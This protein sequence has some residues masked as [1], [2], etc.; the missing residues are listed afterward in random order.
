MNELINFFSNDM[1]AI[2]WPEAVIVRGIILIITGY[3]FIAWRRRKAQM[4]YQAWALFAT[5]VNL[6]LIYHNFF[7]VL[8]QNGRLLVSVLLFTN[9]AIVIYRSWLNSEKYIPKRELK[10]V[11]KKAPPIE[12]ITKTLAVRLFALFQTIIN[13]GDNLSSTTQ[14]KKK[15]C[16]KVLT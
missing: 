10:K 9:S 2:H 16:N 14:V 4:M 5:V 1:Y 6:L 12:F 8:S 13:G 7:D 3:L 11:K 15:I